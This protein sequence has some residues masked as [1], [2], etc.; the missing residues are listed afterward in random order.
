M[1]EKAWTYERAGVSIPKQRSLHEIALAAARAVSEQL[2]VEVEGLGGYGASMKLNGLKLMLHVDGV[3]TKTIV[4]RELNKLWVAGWDC[5]AMN[6]NDVACDRGRPLAV[7]DYISMPEADNEAFAQIME[8]IARAALES[9]IVILGGETAILPDLASGVDV[10]CSVLALKEGEVESLEEGDV[11]VGVESLGLHANGYTLV[12]RLLKHKGLSFSSRVDDLDLS[13]ELSKPTAIY[14]NLLLQAYQ[15]GLAKRAAHITGGG[16][17]KIKRIL[18]PA[19]DAR[20]A[21]PK[22]PRVFEVIQELGSVSSEEMYRVFNMGVGLVVAAKPENA[23]DLIEL[24]ERHGFRASVIGTIARGS[25][26]VLIET[27]RGE[28]LEL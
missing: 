14:S 21:A 16:F 22:P 7:V 26:R 2:K 12:R 27:W 18:G 10:V 1:R 3:G 11:L 25:G 4:L 28:K 17:T 24:A 9:K 5:I 20:I 6:V 8:G 23:D 15:L 13:V 19:L